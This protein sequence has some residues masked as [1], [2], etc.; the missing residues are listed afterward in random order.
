MILVLAACA[1]VQAQE[2]MKCGGFDVV[3]T[4]IAPGEA[5]FVITGEN[6]YGTVD[7]SGTW[8]MTRD[9]VTKVWSCVVTFDE[10]SIITKADGT[11]I[12]LSS[13]TLTFSSD[14]QGQKRIAYQV[15]QYIKSLLEGE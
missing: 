14:Q 9:K 6:D 12:D 4:Q 5:S 11:V 3:V 15:V 13:G 10:G 7:V 1:Y 2:P 8:T